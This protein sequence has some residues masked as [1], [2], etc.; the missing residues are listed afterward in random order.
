MLLKQSALLVILVI[1]VSGCVS[2]VTVKT[3]GFLNHEYSQFPFESKSR[4]FVVLNPSAEN[5]LLDQEIREK[6]HRLLTDNGYVIADR[7]QSDFTIEYTYGLDKGKIITETRPE[8]RPG[9]VVYRS[10]IY[11]QGNQDGTYSGYETTGG[12]IA[13]V[14]VDRVIYTRHLILRVK[15]SRKSESN[16]IWIGESYSSGVDDDLRASMDYL[17]VATFRSFGLDT[18]RFRKVLIDLHDEDIRLLRMN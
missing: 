12:Y 17:L 3:N 10:G 18:K 14:P 6:I 4:F 16:P 13:H 11:K 1:L 8:Y 5:V 7:S 2:G 9:E 15:D